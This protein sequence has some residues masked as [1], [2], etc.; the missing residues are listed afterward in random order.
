MGGKK[1]RCE[2]EKVDRSPSR[3]WNFDI[4]RSESAVGL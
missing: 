2:T 1:D 3:C 4:R